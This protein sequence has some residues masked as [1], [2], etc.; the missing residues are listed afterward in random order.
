MLLE[1]ILAI[2]VGI[3]IGTITGITPGIHV[4]LVAVIA[5]ALSP[6]LLT[7]TTP[8]IIAVFIIT[9]AL[10][11]TFLD[12]IPSI[13]LGAPEDASSALSVLPGHR[14]LLEG[15]GYEAVKLATLGSL[16]AVI[17]VVLVTPLLIPTFKEAY[18]IINKYIPHILI[19]SAVYLIYQS[20]KDRYWSFLVFF[21]SGVLGLA[22]FSISTLEQP[23]LPLLS[24]LFGTSQLILSYKNNVVIPQQK[25]TK[26]NIKKK[27]TL[28]ALG[29][30]TVASTLLGFLPGVGSAQAAILAM[31]VA[32]KTTVEGF[33]VMVGGINTLVMGLSITAL[34]TIDRA[35]N[36]AIVAVSKLIENITVTDLTIFL[37]SSLVV[38][39]L[40]TILTLILARVFSK[41]IT[42]VNYKKLC[43][44]IIILI[45]GMVLL[46]SG[47]VGLL[48]LIISTCLGMIPPLKGIS[49]SHLMGCLMIPVIIFFIL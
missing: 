3:L 22:V 5:L 27:E 14:L 38:A 30:S 45:T 6:F 33:L 31:Q 29:A 34:Y 35:R 7:Y 26:M 16:L 17:I 15:R 13:Y 43:L 20:K 37:A 9:V 24:G 28:K 4:N 48:V 12:S 36:G 42:K 32:G 41:V 11:H 21:L 23:L 2:V 47:P 1:I 25:I 18:P 8:I 44:S 19:A 40:V 10:T 49:R 46:F 39:G